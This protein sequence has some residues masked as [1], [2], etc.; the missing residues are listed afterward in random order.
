MRIRVDGE[1]NALR[2]AIRKSALIRTLSREIPV[3][4]D[5]ANTN[6]G[7]IPGRLFAV[8]EEVRRTA[9]GGSVN[10]TIRDKFHGAAPAS[11][12]KVFRALEAGAQGHFS[13]LRKLSP[14]RAVIVGCRALR[15]SSSGSSVGRRKATTIASSA[16]L[17]PEDRG[18]PGPVFRSWTVSR[19]RPF[20]I[21]FGL[22]PSSRLSAAVDVF[23]RGIAARRAGVVVAQP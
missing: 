3:A 22:I 13:T 10:A 15:Q 7:H 14:G 19:L 1:V 4:L 11:P 18:S 21:V 12:Q 23:D 2:V 9:P 17:R 16:P 20:A 5:P 6:R 8:C